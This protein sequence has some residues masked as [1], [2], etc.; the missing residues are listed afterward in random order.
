MPIIG[1]NTV[2]NVEKYAWNFLLTESQTLNCHGC[3]SGQYETMKQ[4]SKPSL[5]EFMVK[6]IQDYE[7]GIKGIPTTPSIYIY[8]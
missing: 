2:S 4:M 7:E 8:I 3:Q 5:L 6:D 1:I